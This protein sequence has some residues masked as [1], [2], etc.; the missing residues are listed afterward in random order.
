MSE[1][2]TSTQHPAVFFKRDVNL[3]NFPDPRDA[4]FG[5][6][7]AV[8]GS[9]APVNLVAAY[10]RGI[11]PWPIEG[12]PLTWF[13][14]R[15][16]AVLDFRDLHVSRSLA[17][18]RR[19]TPLRF[20]IDADFA[21]TVRGCAQ[22]ARPEQEGTWITGEIFKNYCALH[23]AGHAH[24]VEAWEGD[25]LAGG[26]YGV[27]VGG[28][29]AGESMF[30]RESDA[31]KVALVAL[32]DLLRDAGASLLDVQWSTPHLE[33][34]GVIE[35]PRREYLTRLADALTRPLPPAFA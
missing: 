33:S 24:S 28:L 7:V 25:A 32:V 5:D 11:F 9:L 29:F 3:I 8:G 30:H 14:P 34:L 13:C 12:W 6:I 35:V 1:T 2:E 23:R 15:E 22:A 18:E 10:R 21:G 19:R 31:S 17:R 20:T 27:A 4:P 16:R 26:L